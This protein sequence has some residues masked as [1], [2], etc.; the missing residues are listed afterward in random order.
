MTSKQP[1][2]ESQQGLHIKPLKS[3]LTQQSILPYMSNTF[4]SNKLKIPEKSN[5]T[6]PIQKY[7]NNK[8]QNLP[9]ISSTVYTSSLNSSIKITNNNIKTNKNKL[10]SAVKLT[11]TTKD[12][13]ALTQPRNTEF[14]RIAPLNS[15]FQSSHQIQHHSASIAQQETQPLEEIPCGLSYYPALQSRTPTTESPHFPPSQPPADILHQQNR[16]ST[17]SGHAGSAPGGLFLPASASGT[18]FGGP[19]DYHSQTKYEVPATCYPQCLL[20]QKPTANDHAAAHKM[21]EL[22]YPGFVSLAFG[23]HGEDQSRFLEPQS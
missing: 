13:A 9:Y 15:S 12:N 10:V 14:M 19:T 22:Q 5:N 17:S 2:P 20:Q 21:P 7:E 6:K 4:L 11:T 8:R 3:K 18:E 1:H 16:R 23:A